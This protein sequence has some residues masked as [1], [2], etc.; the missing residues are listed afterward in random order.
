L[1]FSTIKKRQK[2]GRYAKLGVSKL[3]E[4]VTTVY[5]NAQLYNQ[6]ESD[7]FIRAQ[8]GLDTMKDRIERAIR[9]ASQRSSSRSSSSSLS[10][11]NG[12]PAATPTIQKKSQRGGGSG[13]GS[14]SRSPAP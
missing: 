10:T 13:G 6:D 1:D 5:S 14:G 3:W 4:D 8:K 12:T 2:K 9:E 11:F 7:C